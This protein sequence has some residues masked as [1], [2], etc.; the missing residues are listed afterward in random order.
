MEVEDAAPEPLAD[1]SSKS[2]DEALDD[3]AVL[4]MLDESDSA[5]DDRRTKLRHRHKYGYF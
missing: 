2:G 3:A 1:G 5:H 4:E